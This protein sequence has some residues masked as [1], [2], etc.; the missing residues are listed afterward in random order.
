M[1]AA[2]LVDEEGGDQG[3]AGDRGDVGEAPGKAEDLDDVAEEDA[4]ERGDSEP[5]GEVEA[6]DL[7]QLASIHAVR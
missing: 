7:V 6:E 2:G 3:D 1:A 5:D 4:G